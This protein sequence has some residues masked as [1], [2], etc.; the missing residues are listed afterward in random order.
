MSQ[1]GGPVAETPHRVDAE[2]PLFRRR[3]YLAIPDVLADDQQH[4]AGLVFVGQVQIGADPP[5]VKCPDAVVEI[6]QS[7]GHAGKR[8]D[9]QA[10]S[11]AA[12]LNEP[13]LANVERERIGEN[14]DH[15]EADFFSLCQA[16]FGRLLGLH[17]GGI[18]Q[19]EF[20]GIV[21]AVGAPT[22]GFD[23]G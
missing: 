11:V 10:Q 16:E 19:A 6:D 12:V 3:N 8:Y 22:A 20:H 7:D 1:F 4:V 5:K 14:V 23:C 21:D 15:V 2:L 17:P 18:D 9:R 13:T